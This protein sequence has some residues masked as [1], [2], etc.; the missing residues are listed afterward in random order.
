MRTE[1][2]QTRLLK[3]PH[4]NGE[5]IQLQFALNDGYNNFSGKIQHVSRFRAHNW[6]SFSKPCACMFTSEQFHYSFSSAN[7]RC[8]TSQGFGAFFDLSCDC[9]R[10]LFPF[11]SELLFFFP[12]LDSI[13]ASDYIFNNKNNCSTRACWI[14]NNYNHFRATYV[15]RWLSIVYTARLLV[16]KIACTHARL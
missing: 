7:K 15:H 12:F 2:L 3:L 13:A 10:F 8:N 14:S 6:K 11:I 5:I 16:R 4:H 9:D 1:R